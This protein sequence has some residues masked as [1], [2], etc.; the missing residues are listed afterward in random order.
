MICLPW[1]CTLISGVTAAAISPLNLGISPGYLTTPSV[2]LIRG[3]PGRIASRINS[4][5]SRSGVILE[6][7]NKARVEEEIEVHDSGLFL[8]PLKDRHLTDISFYIENQRKISTIMRKF[9]N[10]HG[11]ALL[12]KLQGLSALQKSSRAEDASEFKLAV[13]ALFLIAKYNP[14]QQ[15]D[16]FQ[17]FLDAAGPVFGTPQGVHEVGDLIFFESRLIASEAARSLAKVSD[18]LMNYYQFHLQ[19]EIDQ[20]LRSEIALH[21]LRNLIE[22]ILETPTEGFLSQSRLD[23]FQT[24]RNDWYCNDIFVVRLQI[25]FAY[26]KRCIEILPEFWESQEVKGAFEILEDM[27]DM[28]EELPL[29]KKIVITRTKQALLQFARQKKQR[30]PTQ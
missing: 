1:I 11:L 3:G 30:A 25:L 9:E 7:Q 22:P 29:E 10:C 28:S 21:P 20:M 12:D 18:E 2:D 16:I 13:Q 6:T 27:L 14:P 17:F 5:P 23:L 8:Q 19:S 4:Y 24:A 15:K 26:A